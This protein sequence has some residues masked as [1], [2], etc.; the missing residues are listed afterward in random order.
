MPTAKHR[1]LA[2]IPDLLAPGGRPRKLLLVVPIATALSLGVVT[3]LA[4]VPGQR[5]NEVSVQEVVESLAV[6][7]IAASVQ[8]S[9]AFVR[10]VRIR[11]GDSISSILDRLGASDKEVLS[12]VIASEEGK[13]AIRGMRAGEPVTA[14]VTTAGRILSL[15]LLTN[16]GA[17]RYSVIRQGETIV[18]S[19][20]ERNT[21]TAIQVRGGTIRSSLFA[22]TDAAGL[23]DD[24]AMKLA[25]LFGTEID[26]HTDLRKGDRFS[27]VFESISEGGVDISTGK[28]LAAEFINR[29]K[30]HAVVLF[31]EASGRESYYTPDGR[32][33]RQ[34]FLRSPLEF[35][36]VTSGFAMRFHPIKKMW[37]Q[38]KGVD[39]GAATGTAVKATSDGKVDFVGVQRGYGNVIK[40][41][42]RNEI[43]TVY[44][45]LSRFASGL[46]KGG[47][48]EQGEIIGY[49]GQTGWATGPHLHYEFRSKGQPLDPMSADLPTAQPLTKA[50]MT[51]FRAQV[52]PNIDRL[53]ILNRS[54]TADIASID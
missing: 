9:D 24:V 18:E 30:R 25:E 28:I 7:P 47:A 49:V 20:H 34:A 52:E 14:T 23:S 33:L 43:S 17:N 31:R 22:A 39:F 4:T 10:L 12:F 13:S 1:I 27:V 8:D 37:R 21:E 35:S 5:L 46:K 2:D 41:T 40:L 19:A 38:H 48:V 53:A 42:H 44:A 26:F 29:G 36:R 54:T 11:S 51:R 6:A 32:S 16:A 45:H 15:D 50:E 3:A